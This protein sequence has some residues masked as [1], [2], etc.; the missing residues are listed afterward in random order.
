MDSGS[1]A[2]DTP[3]AKS[4]Y[5]ICFVAINTFKTLV[6]SAEP[7][8]TTKTGSAP[9][10]RLYIYIIINCLYVPDKCANKFAFLTFHSM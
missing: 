7:L 6:G 2:H 1:N 4:V 10:I 3:L 8:I 5:K 9:H